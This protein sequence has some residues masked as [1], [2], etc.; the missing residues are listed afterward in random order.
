MVAI[1][2]F[3]CSSQYF[4][5]SVDVI[6]ERTKYKLLYCDYNVKFETGIDIFLNRVK[7]FYQSN[8]GCIIVPQPVGTLVR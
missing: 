6:C 3:R 2:V 5:R 4:F 8:L 1:I 7:H